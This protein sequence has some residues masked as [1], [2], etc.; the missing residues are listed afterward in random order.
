[1]TRRGSAPNAAAYIVAKIVGNAE[2]PASVV[3]EATE[4]TSRY[5]QQSRPALGQHGGRGEGQPDGDPRSGG[6]SAVRRSGALALLAPFLDVP[7][8]GAI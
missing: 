5:L 1:M 3:I 7:G 6:Y 8:A 4:R 2:V